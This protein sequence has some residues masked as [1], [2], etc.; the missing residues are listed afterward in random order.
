MLDLFCA[1]NV[2]TAI[3]S[4]GVI[5]SLPATPVARAPAAAERYSLAQTPSRPHS[6]RVS[7][8]PYWGDILADVQWRDASSNEDGI[9]LEWWLQDPVSK[10]WYGPGTYT[11]GFNNTEALL[12][13]HSGKNRY[14]VRAFNSAGASGWSNWA[15][16][17]Y[18]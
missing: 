5:S 16:L 7:A 8:V 18:P 9:T 2:C 6:C 17:T 12:R 10:S 14:H 3:L 1:K 13:L 11:V 4:I 15:Y